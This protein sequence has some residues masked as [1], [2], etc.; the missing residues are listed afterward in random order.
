MNYFKTGLDDW[1]W[2]FRASFCDIS[3]IK[4][5]VNRN[6][7]NINY[8]K[9]IDL[10]SDVFFLLPFIEYLEE[11]QIEQIPQ[12][13][14]E[15]I[16]SSKQIQYIPTELNY[17]IEERIHELEPKIKNKLVDLLALANE[18]QFV[19]S[20]NDFY[21]ITLPPGFYEI[22]MKFKPDFSKVDVLKKDQKINLRQVK[23]ITEEFVIEHSIKELSV[24]YKD[25]KSGWAEYWPKD[26]INKEKNLLLINTSNELISEENLINTLK[27]EL[28][29]GHG[30][31]YNRVSRKKFFDDSSSIIIEGWATYSELYKLP[32]DRQKKL[33]ESWMTSA[34]LQINCHP[35]DEK[36][37]KLLFKKGYS[38]RT[39]DLV[40]LNN[41]QMPTYS[42]SYNIGALLLLHL[43]E[44]NLFNCKFI[45]KLDSIKAS[46]F[47]WEH[48]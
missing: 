34:A 2:R 22:L 38:E 20:Q 18:S 25:L 23:K 48:F 14:L 15:Q 45:N 43:S 9:I 6:Q 47:F 12:F 39:V 35:N 21:K 10:F 24:N 3:A 32:E 41:Y 31:F 40:I 19:F 27:H 30:E 13:I 4:K 11:N 42:S 46:D 1:L 17:I 26:L 29:P 8:N 28:Y 5:E 16:H 33:I 37:K 36:V 44:S 7:S